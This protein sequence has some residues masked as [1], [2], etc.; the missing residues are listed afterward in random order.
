V[1]GTVGFVSTTT[2]AKDAVPTGTTQTVITNDV[3]GQVVNGA[4]FFGGFN[5]N[6]AALAGVEFFIVKELS[7]SAE[8]RLG[9]GVTAPYDE[10]NTTGAA[11]VTTKSGAFQTL[12]I[13]SVGAFSLAFYF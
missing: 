9:Y 6:V 7:L 13:T 11:T 10:K 1:G 12:G 5:F 8:Y 3:A 4:T 2:S